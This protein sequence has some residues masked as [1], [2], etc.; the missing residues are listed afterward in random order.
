MV[1]QGNG[2]REPY[3]VEQHVRGPVGVGFLP[4]LDLPMASKG[5]RL[6]KMLAHRTQLA[7]PVVIV[8]DSI[9]ATLVLLTRHAAV[10]NP[11]QLFYGRSRGFGLS[12]TGRHQALILA[13][14]LQ[15][16]P[17]TVFYTSPLLRA[18]QTTSIL[19]DGHPTVP[20]RTATSLTEVRTSW[21]GF[22]TESLPPRANLYE[23]P[24]D[25]Q[26]ETI[27]DLASRMTRFIK[28]IVIRHEDA[29]VCCVSHG[30]PIASAAAFFRGARLELASIRRPWHPQYCSVTQ[31]RFESPNHP[32]NLDYLDVLAVLAPELLE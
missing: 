5:T 27:A 3:G 17:I 12:N 13:E 10:L 16:K 22:P 4:R 25:P 19:S 29:V 26:D 30:D 6:E 2:C 23:P 14:F 8:V 21:A 18:R 11:R 31:L 15:P 20:V 32:P 28:R 1:W 9:M 24:G 7:D